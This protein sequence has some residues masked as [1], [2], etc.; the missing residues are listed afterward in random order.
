MNPDKKT[1]SH[2]HSDDAPATP[3]K[4]Y[5]SY[6]GGGREEVAGGEAG[7]GNDTGAVT[8]TGATWSRGEKSAEDDAPVSGQPGATE[9]NPFSK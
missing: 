9:D 3:V 5:K 8:D 4:D 1:T 2:G 7:H 6:G